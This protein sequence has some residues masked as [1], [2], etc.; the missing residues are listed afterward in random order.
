MK[1]LHCLCP[2][3]LALGQQRCTPQ[4]NQAA[5]AETERCGHRSLAFVAAAALLTCMLIR[6]SSR[7]LPKGSCVFSLAQPGGTV[8]FCS[9]VK[10]V[11][12]PICGYY[13][14][15]MVATW[16]QVRAAVKAAADSS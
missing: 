11:C 7:W 9:V 15:L 12:P 14:V 2:C 16:V 8:D 5:E 3:S 13:L 6:R 10:L 1:A 4:D